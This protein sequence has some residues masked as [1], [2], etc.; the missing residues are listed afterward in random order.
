V[1]FDVIPPHQFIGA[2][3]IRRN[4]WRWFDEYQGDIG[5][6]TH[7]LHVAASED[8]AFARMIHPDSG[9]RQTGRT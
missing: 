1:Y 8:V 5:L 4:F 7:D 6:E 3:D 9:T 2:D